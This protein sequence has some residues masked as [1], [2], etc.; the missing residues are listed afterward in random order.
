[1]GLSQT[2]KSNKIIQLEVSPNSQNK[3][4]IQVISMCLNK[5]NTKQNKCI[6]NKSPKTHT[7][8]LGSPQNIKQKSEVQ[9]MSLSKM[10]K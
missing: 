1:M 6:N 4:T 8:V 2:H 10:L 7:Q 9:T 3:S 5:I